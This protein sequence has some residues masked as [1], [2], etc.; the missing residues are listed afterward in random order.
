MVVK[1]ELGNL[2]KALVSEVGSLNR[3]QHQP[4]ETS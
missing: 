4:G 1:L 2:W 3:L